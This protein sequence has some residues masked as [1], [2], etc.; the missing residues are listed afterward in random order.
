[1]YAHAQLFSH[2]ERPWLAGWL[3]GSL[4]TRIALPLLL[5]TMSSLEKPVDSA[6]PPTRGRR[7]FRK[8]SGEP[9]S[10]TRERHRA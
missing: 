2:L 8:S 10:L 4:F 3:A 1:M 7:L 5:A 6:K 9:I